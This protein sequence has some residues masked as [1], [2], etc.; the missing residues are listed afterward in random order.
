MTNKRK[1]SASPL[2]ESIYKSKYPKE[3]QEYLDQSIDKEEENESKKKGPGVE[4]KIYTKS[5]EG[6]R[7][8]KNRYGTIEE[9]EDEDLSSATPL[10]HKIVKKKYRNSRNHGKR[11]ENLIYHTDTN[12]TVEQVFKIK[13]KKRGK[14]RNKRSQFFKKKEENKLETPA[15]IKIMDVIPLDDSES[16]EGQNMVGKLMK[17]LRSKSF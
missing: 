15:R 11:T 7:T 9:N 6:G 14:H 13:K 8:S 17:C 10:H 5:N 2:N 4:L 16:K 12:S 3:M 1:K